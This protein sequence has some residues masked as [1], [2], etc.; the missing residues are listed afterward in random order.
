MTWTPHTPRHL[1]TAP[2]DGG[3]SATAPRR[4]PA[5]SPSTV[6]HPAPYRDAWAGN[7]DTDKH[8]GKNR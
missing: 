7:P 3:A 5:H 8:W 4:D 2:T 1:S 6:P